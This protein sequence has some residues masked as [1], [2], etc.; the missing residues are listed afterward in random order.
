MTAF[1]RQRF[2]EI[3]RGERLGD[4]G[5][6]G[7]GIHIFWPE[8]IQAWVA[9]GAPAGFLGVDDL[10]YGTPSP[11]DEFFG[12]DPSRS[13]AEV[14]SGMD[15]GTRMYE[16]VPGVVAHDHS[17]LLNPPF[18][19]QVLEEDETS[20]VVRD[21]AGI[22]ERLLKGKA[23]NMPAWLDHPVKDRRS[24]AQVKAR[25]D[26]DTPGRYPADWEAYAAAIN[27]LD[28]PVSMEVGG[29]FGY[30]NMWVG[31]EDLMYLF[32]DDPDLVE[33]MMETVLQL[34]MAMVKRVTRDIRL[35]WVWYWEDMAYKSGPMISPKMV[36]TFMLPR[37]E[38]LNK[39]IRDAGCDVLYLDCDGNVDELVPIWLDAGI[40]LFW[41][42]EI[43]AG[44]DPLA[45]RR[46]Y[47]KEIILAGGLD[48]RE[49]MKDKA[50][51]RHEVLT[52]V[53]ALA[54]TGPYFPSPDHLVP[55]D[56][57]FENFCV[58]IELLREIR[59]DEP[60]GLPGAPRR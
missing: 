31:T 10:G 37:Y 50:S 30:L 34:E 14:H 13:L 18:T 5:I 15:A 22:S 60:L 35:D 51:L 53:R 54:D 57:P 42:L 12:F 24:W 2:R 20:V 4:F 3:C 59:G 6:L 27:A 36:R 29:F 41:P 17:F 28:C 11:V 26:P 40:N 1:T 45:L 19:P 32:Y 23:F 52:K 43:A 33:D 39:V 48:K 9:Q 38:R 7:N 25:L 16:Y 21:S 8:T 44:T 46:K 49:L 47:G 56:M 58:Y 55:I